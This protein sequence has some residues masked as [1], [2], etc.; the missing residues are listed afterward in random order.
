MA[1][2]ADAGNQEE[3]NATSGSGPLSVLSPRE[4][5]IMLQALLSDSNFPAGIQVDYVKVA[6]RMNLKNPRSVSNAWSIIKNKIAAYDKKFREDHNLPSAEQ[7]AAATAAENP[8]DDDN[9]S[10]K[11]RARTNKSSKS[12][13]GGSK[14]GARAKKD[15]ASAMPDNSGL[16]AAAGSSEAT[17]RADETEEDEEKKDQ[18]KYLAGEI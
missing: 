7:E 3:S 1:P 17:G 13:A 18:D 6:N 5:T 12:A 10:P 9:P 16:G 4:Q 2:K 11:K 8:E 15:A 14:R